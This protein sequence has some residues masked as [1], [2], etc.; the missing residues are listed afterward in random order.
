MLG[1]QSSRRLRQAHFSNDLDAVVEIGDEAPIASLDGFVFDQAAGR[2]IFHNG[3][4]VAT[5]TSTAPLLSNAGTTLG[6][7]RAFGSS[8]FFHGDLAEVLVYERALSPDEITVVQEE[9]A[10]IYGFELVPEP[11]PAAFAMAGLAGAG[12]LRRRRR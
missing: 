3:E 12:L 6:N 2:G 7:F 5:D 10:L 1:Y 9:L 4:Q 8:Y 11:S